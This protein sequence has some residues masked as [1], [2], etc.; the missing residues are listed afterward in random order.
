MN[1]SGFS[2]WLASLQSW[3]AYL[4]DNQSVAKEEEEEN[5]CIFN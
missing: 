2:K 4:Q 1:I 5:K 3:G